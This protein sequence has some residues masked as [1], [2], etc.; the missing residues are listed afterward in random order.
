MILHLVFFKFHEPFQWCDDEVIDAEASTRQHPLHIREILG[1]ACGR[2]ISP[3]NR[4]VDFAV[5]GLF[6]NQDALSAFL[7]HPNH[8]QG[9]SKW[10]KIA[11]WQVVDLDI[12]SDTTKF[13]GL[14]NDWA[15]SSLT[16][17][18]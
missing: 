17:F 10:Q 1:W 15:D 13:F 9:V 2:N 5:M 7:I 8:Q 18:E 16:Q 4:A 11:S 14:I 3:R 12:E 6:D